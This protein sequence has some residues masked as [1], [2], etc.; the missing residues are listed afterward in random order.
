MAL[1][2]KLTAIGDAIREK[3]GGTA[4]LSL[5]Q[6]VDEIGV[7]PSGGGYDT[8]QEDAFIQ[9]TTVDYVNDRVTE[10]TSYAFANR[11][12]PKTVTLPNVITLQGYVFRGNTGLESINLPSLTSQNGVGNFYDCTSL[13][14][15]SLPKLINGSVSFTGCTVLKDV[16][17]SSLIVIGSGPF[18]DCAAITKLEFPS[19]QTFNSGGI[20]NTVSLRTLILSGETVVKMF[21]TDAFENTPIANGTGYVYVPDNLV[22]D[23]KVA[24]NWATY[25]DQ[26]KPLSEYVEVTE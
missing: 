18:S 13:R 3:T 6:M 9:G 23:Y 10:L 21:S 14:S 22:E 5:D 17:L 1:T 15:V 8:T 2:D 19:L 24:T 16:D 25:A 26:I 7:I 4:K 20:K 11:D 12:Y